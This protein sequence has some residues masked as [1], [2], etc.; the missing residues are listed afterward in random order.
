MTSIKVVCRI[1]PTNQLE[2][3]LGG[4]N[5]I[6]PLNDSTVH[7]ETSDYSGNFVFDRVFHPSST[8]NDI[9]SYSIE[10]TVDDLF[11]GYN[12]T[13]LAY[14]QTGSGKTYTMMGIENNFEKEGMTPRM[15]RRI[16]D[17]I[18]DSP[19]TTEYEVKVSYMEIYMEKIHDLLSEKNDRLTVHED[20]LQGVYVQGL[21]TIYVSSETEALDILNKGMGSR[22]VASTSMNAQSSRSHSIFVLEVVQTDTESGETRRGRLF[23]VDLAG[24]ESVGKSGAV[25]QTLEEAKKINRSLSTLG[26]VI[27]SLTDSKL[28]HVPYRDSKLTRILKES[29]GGNSRT[30][31]II[32]C[33]P[34]SYNATETLSTLRFGHRA[35]SIKNKAVV[36][37]ELSVDEMKRQL[38]IY[39]DALSRCVC[40]ARI[41][42]NLDYNN[43]HSNVWS[44][45]HSLTLSNLAEKSNL[46]EAEIIQG[47]RTIQES[48]NDRD[49][50]TVASIHRHNFDSDSINRL[51]AEA[52][53][54]LKQR[55]GVLS[56]TKQQLSDL[57]TALGDAQERYV[58][59]VKNH[60]VNSN[61]TANNSLND[62]PGF[63]IEQ[64]DKNFSINNE[65][66]NFLQKLS[67][68]D[69][70]LAALV[71]VQR[72]LIKALISK[73]RPQNGTV[74]KKIQ[75]GT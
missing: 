50:S 1:R 35:K 40:G 68:L 64:K 4:N 37:S 70:S 15:L 42:N 72:K 34:D 49:E 59:L 16:F 32:N 51:Y 14:G 45:E 18:R 23:L 48:N 61:L 24:S 27:N 52:Q 10:S 44:G 73:E 12:G 65:R 47:N 6:Y 22:A 2:Q 38:Y 28:S 46:K 58:E 43:C 31:L 21:K 75:G 53:L 5:V 57:M 20:K 25:G 69:S 74:I 62:K 66:N 7:I 9:F 26:M 3:D 33:S 19:S 54:E 36:N 17:K 8:L 39:K 55:D 41:N 60:R 30:T 71:N 56:S 11:L 29:L 63:T 13:V 67:T